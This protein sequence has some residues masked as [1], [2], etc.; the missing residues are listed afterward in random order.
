MNRL[1]LS[2]SVLIAAWCAAATKTPAEEPPPAQVVTIPLSAMLSAGENSSDLLPAM[3]STASID[4]PADYCP[5]SQEILRAL[6]STSRQERP[7][8]AFVVTGSPREALV[9][10][11]D[12]VVNQKPMQSEFAAYDSLPL[13]FMSYS[14]FHM[15]LKPVE[16]R[17][18]SNEIVVNYFVRMSGRGDASNHFIL[19]PLGQLSAGSYR[20]VID[21]VPGTSGIRPE[22]MLLGII[23]SPG[24]TFTVK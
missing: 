21:Q 14:G 16:L 15:S 4:P 9:K 19:I 20:V 18:D 13:V 1:F 7:K 24:F 22:R 11:H 2:L 10:A 23:V 6:D 3:P 17:K 8:T 5:L 12:V